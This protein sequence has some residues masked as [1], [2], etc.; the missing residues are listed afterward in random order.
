M[1]GR[2]TRLFGRGERL[3][4][5][6][7]VAMLPTAKAEAHAIVKQ[8]HAADER[9][10][11][12]GAERFYRAAVAA[13]PAC[14]D[15]HMNL[16]NAL[17]GRGERS[18]AIAC[19]ERAVALDPQHASAHYNLGLALINEGSPAR[20]EQLFRTAL[21]LRAS[22]PQAWFGLALVQEETGDPNGAMESY[23][24]AVLLQPDY[25]EAHAGLGLLYKTHGQLGAAI[26]SLRKALALRPDFAEA[27]GDLGNALLEQGELDAA[28]AAYRK[29]LALKPDHV[30]GYGN[31][32][33][34]LNYHP[35]L[36]AEEIF[37][38]YRD[39]DRQFATPHR[40]DWREHPNDRNAAR[41]LKIGYVSPDYCMHP[42]RHFLEPL[43]A[44]HDKQS[45]EIF[46]YSQTLKEDHVT[47]RYK[48]LVDHWLVTRQLND[49]ALANRIRADGIDILVDLAGHTAHN[50]LV[51][52]ARKPAPVSLSWLGFGYTT[53]VSAIDYLMTDDASVPEGSENLFAEAPWR[54]AAPC[55][56]YRPAEGMGDV[57]ELPAATHGFVTFGTLTRSVR[58]NH[59]TIRVWSV[60]LK[61]VPGSRLLVDSRNYL[62]AEMRDALAAKFA[63]HGIPRD[64]LELGAHS[65]PW[66]VL[67]GIDIGLDCFPHNSGTTLFETLYMGIPFVTLAGRPSVGRLGSSILRGIDH[68]EWI[69]DSEE[70]YVQKVVALA[71][72]LP[73]LA[74][75]RSNL[76]AEIQASALMDEAGFAQKVE[77][78]YR[79]MFARWAAKAPT[80]T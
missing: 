45:F 58:I 21:R 52:F 72:D 75:L 56:A 36:S 78:A 29:A 55:Y 31:L 41:R 7:K 42:V 47:E 23:H 11:F 28:I 48:R 66:D 79:E 80:L 32:L 39:F 68:A 70:E 16:G 10:D 9:G 62:D 53:G 61:R 49:D 50:R 14:A 2:W 38:A 30:G 57:N 17:N 74:Q 26:G 22:F 24:K 67:R 46:A 64:R 71:S 18:A 25:A 54:L 40:S 34:T 4:P 8:G 65:P 27:T 37:G 76:R 12:E 20:V 35:D 43:L 63:A 15:A 44:N 77:A 69:A 3:L 1:S 73:R 19:Y 59:R 60:L 51:A 33:F 6:Q 5:R 13:D